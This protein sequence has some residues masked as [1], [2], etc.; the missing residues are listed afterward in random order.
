M[1]LKGGVP[2]ADVSFDPVLRLNVGPGGPTIAAVTLPASELS[3][4]LATEHFNQFA[5]ITLQP[6]S[7]Y[8]I[9]VENSDLETIQ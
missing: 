7:L 6:N 5:S 8:R 4:G 9:D 2:L 3:A 1:S